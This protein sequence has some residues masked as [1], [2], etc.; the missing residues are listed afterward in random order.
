MTLQGKLTPGT[1]LICGCLCK[2]AKQLLLLALWLSLNRTGKTDNSR[3]NFLGWGFYA[4]S[5]SRLG[6]PRVNI[7][8][9]VFFPSTAEQC[10]GFPASDSANNI[11][12]PQFP[13]LWIRYNVDLLSGG[14][15]PTWL[16]ISSSIKPSS[17]MDL[18]GIRAGA[19]PILS[20]PR[21]GL[22]FVVVCFNHFKFFFFGLCSQSLN[23]SLRFIFPAVKFSFIAIKLLVWIFHCINK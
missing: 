20:I 9:P 7:W 6:R 1:T 2:A 21:E 17:H 4:F 16:P 14:H 22:F 10:G 5:F 12:F 3:S 15:F 23:D 19:H 11:F 8:A 13:S 18:P